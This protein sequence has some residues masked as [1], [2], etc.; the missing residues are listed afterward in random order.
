MIVFRFLPQKAMERQV[1]IPCTPSL[2]P[3]LTKAME[4]VGAEF[5]LEKQ[6]HQGKGFLTMILTQ[7]SW[8]M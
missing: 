6:G 3:S 7:D 4:L 2:T 8:E 1:Q 5:T